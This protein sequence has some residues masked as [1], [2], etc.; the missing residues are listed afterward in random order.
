MI[1]SF[2]RTEYRVKWRQALK[3]GKLRGL[4]MRSECNIC[5]A[6]LDCLID[7]IEWTG[8]FHGKIVKD[9]TL[10]DEFEEHHCKMHDGEEP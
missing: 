7:K 9:L 10:I 1:V 8:R 3:T 2:T 4:Y 5:H 6:Y